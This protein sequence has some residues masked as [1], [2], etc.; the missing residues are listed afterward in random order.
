L[1]DK[2]LDGREFGH[3]PKK[4]FLV[5]FGLLSMPES[6]EEK[7]NGVCP[8]W[9]LWRALQ[10]AH[11]CGRFVPDRGRGPLPQKTERTEPR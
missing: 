2:A 7:T 9:P 4:I 11:P 3:R 8:N 1:F 5:V 10:S 6:D